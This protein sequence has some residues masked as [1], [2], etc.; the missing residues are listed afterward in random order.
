M[1]RLCLLA[2]VVISNIPGDEGLEQYVHI[3]YDISYL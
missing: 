1:E 2:Y 3:V